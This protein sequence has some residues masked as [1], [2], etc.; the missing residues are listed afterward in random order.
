M[1]TLKLNAYSPSEKRE[2]AKLFEEYRSRVVVNICGKQD[3]YC[4]ECEYKHL[5]YDVCKAFD[6]IQAEV[7]RD[8]DDDYGRY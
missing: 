7:F 3:N 4:A 6:Y 2:L 5:C 1:I 8:I